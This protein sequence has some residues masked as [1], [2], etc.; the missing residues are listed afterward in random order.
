[1]PV[2]SATC[3]GE[4]GTRSLSSEALTQSENLE[5]KLEIRTESRQS[6]HIPVLKEESCVLDKS[7]SSVVGK[8]QSAT[9]LV[10][11]KWC[12]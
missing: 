3:G 10:F 9:P 4:Q 11:I 8:C 7:L 1:M 12:N 5:S 2:I 6:R